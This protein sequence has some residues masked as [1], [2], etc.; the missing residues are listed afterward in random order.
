MPK[1]AFILLHDQHQW[2]CVLRWGRVYVLLD[3]LD[4]ILPGIGQ[5]NGVMFHLVETNANVFYAAA[6]AIAHRSDEAKINS[7]LRLFSKRVG[8]PGKENNDLISEVAGK[9]DQRK[10][11]RRFPR[12]DVSH[13]KSSLAVLLREGVCR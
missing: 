6:Y 5:R 12:L 11:V 3:P 2:L 1:H 10:V 8:H 9:I 13:D 4:K 7:V